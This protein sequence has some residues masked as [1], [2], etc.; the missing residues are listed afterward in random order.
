MKRKLALLAMA[1][2]MT[3]GFAHADGLNVIE[4]RQAGQDLFSASFSGIRAVVAAKGDVKTVAP[5]AA[6][7][8][9]WMR[10]YPSLFPVGSDKGNNT[11]ALPTVWSDPAGFQKFASQ[12]A[13]EA[14][15]MAQSAKAGDTDGVAVQI[16][17]V[18][19]V[20]VACHKTY[21]AT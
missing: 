4:V 20:C 18:G 10:S 13:E 19:E 14:D 5:A 11:K 9:R 2:V 12:L 16:K 6:A 17:A 21:R 3:V 8:A 7:M 1:G 15:K